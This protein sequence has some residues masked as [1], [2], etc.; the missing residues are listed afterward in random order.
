MMHGIYQGPIAC[1]KTKT[2]L[3]QDSPKAAT[4]LAQ[5]DDNTTVLGYD[6]WQFPRNDFIIDPQVDWSVA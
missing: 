4:I 5:F 1:L 6:W 2:A 3:L